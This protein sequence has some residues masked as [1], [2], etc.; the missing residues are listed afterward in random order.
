MSRTIAITGATGFIGGALV[1]AM[2]DLGWNVRALTRARTSAAQALAERGVTLVTG[3][4]GDHSALR[5]LCEGAD[6]VIHC[7]A[8]MGKGD[9]SKSERVNVD[10]TSAVLQ[11]AED[12]GT[13]LF[14]YISS[15]SVYRGTPS[16]T[17]VFTEDIEPYAHP[18]LNN[19]SRTKLAGEKVVQAFCN[20]H[21]LDFVILRPT[22]V[23]GPG[24]RPWG[25]DV[26]R[27]VRRF[28]LSFGNVV[29]NF[30]HIDDLVQS[31]LASV[32]RPGARNHVFNVGSQPLALRAFYE[33]VARQSG[34]K[35]LRIPGP[36]DAAIRHGVDRY[37]KLRGQVRSTG[38][39]VPSLYPHDKAAR[40]LN[41]TPQHTVDSRA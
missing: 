21:S 10:G 12:A 7:A 18:G 1:H 6:A 17:R 15:I 40:L 32:Q 28:H 38:Y 25:R 5:N 16:A 14:V 8:E 37:A 35:V 30:V 34:T 4:L 22:N 41:Y 36:I 31:I 26:Q 27:F 24:C 33:H 2:C 23:Y 3:D 11:A 19:Y 20:D 9:R 13:G 39:S 29:F